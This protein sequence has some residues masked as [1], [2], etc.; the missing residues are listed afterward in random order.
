MLKE[1]I[2]EFFEVV[3]DNSKLSKC[4]NNRYIKLYLKIIED[5]FINFPKIDYSSIVCFGYPNN[6]YLEKR[7][8]AFETLVDKIKSHTVPNKEVQMRNFLMSCHSDD[9]IKENEYRIYYLLFNKSEVISKK[10]IEKLTTFNM[11]NKLTFPAKFYA[12]RYGSFVNISKDGDKYFISSS[13]DVDFSWLKIKTKKD[14]KASLLVGVKWEKEDTHYHNSEKS[15]WI[16]SL[17]YGATK[18]QSVVYVRKISDNSIIKEFDNNEIQTEV[19]EPIQIDSEEIAIKKL[20]KLNKLGYMGLVCGKHIYTSE[21]FGL[22][23]L[24]IHRV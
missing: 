4:L 23:N 16:D 14:F 5:K 19:L 11:P 22:N 12:V 17:L 13:V 15:K 8:V 6:E 9:S 21:T 7:I 3:K 24:D 1:D 18:E 10:E 2:Q 20:K